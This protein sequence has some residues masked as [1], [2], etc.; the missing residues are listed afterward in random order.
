MAQQAGLVDYTSF[1]GASYELESWLG[2]RVA[3]LI[4]EA[5]NVT[6]GVM[7]DLLAALDAGYNY[8]AS[9]TRRE[10]APAL[11]VQG[12]TSIAVV[13]ETCGAGCG[14]LGSTGIE[15]IPDF[16]G[17]NLQ[18][19]FPWVDGI[20]DAMA[21]RGEVV[22]ILFYEL[23]RNFWFYGNQLG[24]WGLTTGYAVINRFYA[25]QA[26]GHAIAA[27]DSVYHNDDL[28]E[29]ARTYFTSDAATG[30]TTLGTNSGIVNATNK[31]GAPDLAAALFRLLGEHAGQVDYAA[32]WRALES[33]PFAEGAQAAFDNFA[34]AAATASGLDFS[35]LFKDGWTFDVGTWQANDLTASAHSGSLHAVIGLQGD[36]T[37][38]GSSGSES[39]FG[40]A[41]ADTLNGGAGN[42]QLA[43]GS[44]NDVLDGGAGNDVLHGGEGA[45]TMRGRTGNDTYIVD[46]PGDDIAEAFGEGVDSV[47][48]SASHTLRTNFENL[49]LTGTSPIDGRGNDL[50]NLVL[51]NEGANRLYGLAGDD[52]LYGYAGNDRF[53]GGAGVDQLYG[54]S[55]NDTYVFSDSADYAY[56][57]VDEGTDRVYASVSH[58]LRANIEYLYLTGTAALTGAGNSIANTVVG[59]A[60]ANRLYGMDGAD[61]LYGGGGNDRLDGGAAADVLRGGAGNDVYV[62]DN[63]YD[64]AVEAAGAGTDTVQ[65][66][67]TLTLRA[68]VENLLATGAAAINA[69]GNDLANRMTGNGAA[70]ALSGAAGNDRLLGLD[71]ADILRGG[72]GNDW[73]EGGAGQDRMYG[74]LGADSFV[75]DDGHFGGATAASADQVHDF[76]DAEGD[77]VRLD[78]VDANTGLAGDQAFTLIGTSAFSNTA[79]E[80]RYEQISGN[81]YVQ[82]DWDGD[83]AADFWI[84]LDGLHTLASDD[85]IF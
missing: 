17:S 33:A 47:R 22:G 25:M 14:Y 56:E 41:G 5:A 30:L 19:D 50:S 24:D 58:T 9:I 55:G 23:G 73:L 81:T 10:P 27:A 84:R 72:D 69:T 53:D 35:F 54:G 83:G 57:N 75:F 44:A 16:F 68:N 43:G 15:F 82:G 7:D 59:N 38:S 34:A 71:A 12:R 74:G 78:L 46:N 3:L 21:S 62:V 51:G 52:K 18:G 8:Y 49:T 63:A 28:P 32:F 37:L 29:I 39:L 61:Q 4:P 60:A 36:D 31:N 48:S 11:L 65:S 40:D 6:Q 76:G 1:V 26:T 64:L 42:D 2:D 80:L 67:A 85:F 66:S 13:D 20:Y 77:R 79:G 45:D 70:N